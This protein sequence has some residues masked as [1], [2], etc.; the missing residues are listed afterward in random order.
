VALLNRAWQVGFK[1]GWTARSPIQPQKDENGLLPC[2]LCGKKVRYTPEDHDTCMD[3]SI[4][5]S[6]CNL[7]IEIC[8]SPD[9]HS[10]HDAIEAWNRRA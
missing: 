9:K 6:A 3:G 5:C 1:F 10:I 4:Q 2:P 7:A 8:H